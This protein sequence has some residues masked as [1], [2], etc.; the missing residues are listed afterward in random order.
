MKRAELLSF[1]RDQRWAVACTVSAAEAPQSALVGIAVTAAFEL[2][3][4][5]SRLS[6]KAAN[7]QRRRAISFVIGGWVD[8]DERTVQY[9]GLADMPKGEELERLKQTYFQA[10]PEGRAR[11]TDADTVYF[12]ARPKWIRY[13][14]FNGA[15]PVIQV[16]EF[17]VPE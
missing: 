4:D 12:R 8:G 13:S 17:D 9:E 2:V 14:D 16:F 11:A 6:R 1:L 5:T 7:L 3:F 10:F 15:Q